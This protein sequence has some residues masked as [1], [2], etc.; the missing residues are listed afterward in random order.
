MT[1]SAASS[2]PSP[3]PLLS[4]GGSSRQATGW[5]ALMRTVP[6]RPSTGRLCAMKSSPR[7]AM[8]IAFSM[9]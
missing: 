9:Q 7:P 4:S 5:L 6:L 3:E 2:V 8:R 1:A